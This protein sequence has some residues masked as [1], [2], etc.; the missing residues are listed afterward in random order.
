MCVKNLFSILLLNLFCITAAFSQAIGISGVADRSA[1]NNQVS[2]LI[3]NN[4]GFTY[5]ATLDG[6]SVPVGTAVL[7]N[8]I[9]YHEL[10]VWRTNTSTLATSNRLVRFVVTTPGRDCCEWG[11]PPWTPYPFINSAA[12]EFAGANLR[13]L[14]PQD[15][16]AGMDI[17]LIAWV[18]DNAGHAVRVNGQLTS[19]NEQVVLIRRGVGSGLL[20]PAS[21]GPLN[22]SPQL[23]SLA[24]NKVINIESST[25]WTSVSG[26]L[27]G[28]TTWPD[29]SRI[30]VTGN[31][32]IPAGSSLTVGAGSVVRLASKANIN[33]AGSITVNGTSAKPVVWTPFTATQPWGGIM[34]SNTAQVIATGT[35]WT[36]GGGEGCFYSGGGAACGT[37]VDGGSHRPEQALFHFA[38]A[39]SLTL[40]NCA[41]ISLA[42]QFGHFNNGGNMNLNHVLIQRC[43][44]GGQYSVGSIVMND[45][46]I[47]EVPSDTDTFV[48]GDNDGM[49]LENGGYS[50]TNCL[51]GWTKDDGFDSG[52]GGGGINNFINCWFESTYHEGVSGSGDN[53]YNNMKDTVVMNCGQAFEDGYSRVTNA[54]NNCLYVGNVTGARFGDNY[55]SGYVYTGFLS[56]S[57]SYLLYNYRNV[58]GMTFNLSGTGVDA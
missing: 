39:G 12:G 47:I 49:Y 43:T 18:E 24:A 26:N 4:A 16:P 8:R 53:K 9:D 20:K 5:G 37:S 48:D 52:G 36:G 11:L 34:M 2:F 15:Y 3:T 31:V 42:G 7:V 35:I 19:T 57:N 23:S 41:A 33:L 22:Y 13:L 45:C 58:W 29:D 25:T 1:Y 28:S 14:T 32:T 54:A 21:A 44:S 56:V 10:F 27:S 40:S 6:N 55:S 46:A 38:A 17:P 51:V 50:F 30:S